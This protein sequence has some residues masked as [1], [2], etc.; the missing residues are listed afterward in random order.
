MN[1]VEPTQKMYKIGLNA[2]GEV[3][4]ATKHKADDKFGFEIEGDFGLFTAP[5]SGG[6]KTS[7]P[8]PT[9]SAIKGIIE[10]ISFDPDVEVVPLKVYIC[11]PPVFMKM[12]YNGT[13][14]YNRKESSIK[15]GNASQIE[16]VVLCRPLYQI[17]AHL[18]NR[19][20]SKINKAHA[21][22]NRFQ[23]RIRRGQSFAP[24]FLGVSQFA[25]TYVGP[26]RPETKVCESYTTVLPRMLK[27]P[28][29]EN[30]N[31]KCELSPR[32]YSDLKIENGV[33]AYP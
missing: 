17:E 32:W 29:A 3:F 33:L 7:Y 9:Y 31:S 13:H 26:F 14:I 2:N 11:R 10:S 16:Q 22:Q 4:D 30:Q 23:K 20:R 28:F 1:Y 6:F 15:E 27:H 24:V 8:A 19:S 12:G 5:D 21:F 18:L 25:A